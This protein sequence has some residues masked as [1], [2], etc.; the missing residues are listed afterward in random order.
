M[1]PHAVHHGRAPQIVAA[2]QDTQLAAYARHPQRFV[3]QPPQPPRLPE[4]AW[5]NPPV[6]KTT[7]PQ[8]PGSTISTLDDIWTPPDP[9]AQEP[10]IIEAA[11]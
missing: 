9:A 8:A 6:E 5:I 4:K 2:R 11:H 10:G 3:H 1:T 7:R